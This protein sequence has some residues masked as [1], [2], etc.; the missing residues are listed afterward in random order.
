MPPGTSQ[1][2][3]RHPATQLWSRRWK[4]RAGSRVQP[5][6]DHVTSSYYSTTVVAR[7]PQALALLARLPPTSL[8]SP[9]LP[10]NPPFPLTT[11]SCPLVT[12]VRRILGDPRVF[13]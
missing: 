7:P 12:Y 13:V 5:N 6:L 11:K 8:H 9:S 3:V 4:R 2:N 10:Y 1:S